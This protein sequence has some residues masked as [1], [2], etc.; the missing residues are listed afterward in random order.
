[1]YEAIAQF[2]KKQKDFFIAALLWLGIVLLFFSPSVFNNKVIAPND[3]LECVFRP[4]ADKPIENVHNQ[5][6]VD[7]VSQYLPYK[8]SMKKS[9]DEDGYIGWNPYTFN[10][11]AIPSNTMTSPGDWTNLLYAVMP[12]WSAWDLGIILQFYVAGIGIILLLRHYKLPIWCCLLAAI[13]FA[14]YSQFVLW[15]YHRWLEAM[16]WAPYV[17]WAMIKYRHRVIN[18]PAIFFMAMLWRGGHL[19]SCLFG[20]ILVACVW[21][22]EIWKRDGKW[23][24]VKEMGRLTLSCFLIGAI[25]ALLS[26]DV[27]I[28]TL[29][30]LEGCKELK[31]E[32]GGNTILT[33][34][35]MLFPAS[36]G[37]P[38][39]LDMF[40]IVDLSLFDIKFGGSIVLILS[41]IACFNKRAPRVAKFLFVLSLLAVCTPLL[42][43]LYSR[44]TLIMSLGMAWLAAWQIYDLTRNP[45]KS[46]YWKRIAYTLGCIVLLWLCASVV[47]CC[48]HDELAVYLNNS[49]K[50]SASYASCPGRVEWQEQ[51]VELFLSQILVWHWQ[52][53]LQVCVLFFGIF[54]CYKIRV[55]SKFNA[56]W[57]GMVAVLTCVEMFSFAFTWLTYSEKP[58]GRYLYNEPTWMPALRE[59]VGDGSLTF[60]CPARDR[61]FLCTN[62]FSG[63]DIR[64]ADGYETF[65]PKYLCPSQEKGL[66]CEN[67]AAAG[68]SHIFV[69]TKWKDVSLPG[70]PLVMQEKEFK[71]YANPLFKG[72]YIFDEAVSVKAEKRT[73]NRIQLHAPAGAKTLTVYESYHDGWK[74]YAGNQ[75][76][77]IIPTER[78]A[79]HM[80]LPESMESYDI[81][82]EFR[83]PYRTLSYVIMSL[84]A[85]FLLICLLIQGRNR[86]LVC[87]E[88]L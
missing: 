70:L 26:I 2:L 87:R 55:G 79:M 31:Q 12:F 35:T 66:D 73:C 20:F 67:Y 29:S 11:N 68:I 5:F 86:R 77:E 63:Y 1:M 34:G 47:I 58:E 76:L 60:I 3:C 15:I 32:W 21:L 49:I 40:K 81:M 33:L 38:Q 78:G 41:L 52:N 14:F 71:V 27:F 22:A 23:L 6:V 85:L 80:I 54:C 8:W 7:G 45:I 51:R 59:H 48:Y 19:Q 69:D 74:A 88:V 24:P 30:N 25:G 28:N 43:Q 83:M 46:V 75:E 44:S 17:V 13:S 36:L 9:L 62:H 56:T 50:S 10:G 16:I 4:I 39:T 53:L 82:M 37:V 84:T 18:V 72:R 42:T 64:I 61:D 57:G 65:R